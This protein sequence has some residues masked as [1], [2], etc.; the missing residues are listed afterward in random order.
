MAPRVFVHISSRVPPI[1]PREYEGRYVRI[2]HDVERVNYVANDYRYRR[3]IK[4]YAANP[5]GG[6][7]RKVVVDK[8]DAMPEVVRVLPF[9]HTIVDC[10][11]QGIWRRMNFELSDKRWST[12]MNSKLAWMNMTGV[13][14]PSYKYNCITGE[15]KPSVITQSS[16]PRFDQPRLCGGAVV[17][18]DSFE[19]GRVWLKSLKIYDRSWT[20]ER[21]L[22]ED[23]LWYW[24]T[25]VNPRGLANFITRLGLDGTYKRVRIPFLTAM[26]VY[27]PLSEVHLLP[28]GTHNHA[29]LEYATK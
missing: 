21:V 13:S 12:L 25:S 8:N 26:N 22:A 15:N 7:V 28:E 14:D 24:G 6:P 16:Y 2:P 18:V 17:K 11:W 4:E 29:V 1:P 23:H 19:N 27:L 3:N 5:W 20:A 9:H 10:Y